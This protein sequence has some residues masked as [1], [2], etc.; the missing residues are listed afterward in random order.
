MR[1]LFPLLSFSAFLITAAVL[2]AQRSDVLP[3]ARRVPVV[4]G[5]TQL[6]ELGQP[7]PLPE[8][9]KNP[10][11]PT[12]TIQETS[13]APARAAAPAAITD[14]QLLEAI[15]RQIDPTGTVA[16]GG[17][18]MLLF[19]QKRIKVG[20]ALPITFDGKPYDIVIT[21][22]QSTSFTLRLRGEEITRSIKPAN[23]P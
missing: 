9:L 19:G 8:P 10:F 14:R 20:D 18:P 21:A 1:T 7:K 15:A 13:Q 3:P 12:P 17:E 23:R 6:A 5:A 22:I 11:S 16:I 2:S 4:E